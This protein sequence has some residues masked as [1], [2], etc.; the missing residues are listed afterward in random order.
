MNIIFNAKTGEFELDEISVEKY[1]GECFKLTF[2]NGFSF[3]LHPDCMIGITSMGVESISDLQ[4]LVLFSGMVKPYIVSCCELEQYNG[5]S[6]EERETLIQALQSSCNRFENYIT[7]DD[8]AD[9]DITLSYLERLVNSL[10]YGTL[11][12][13]AT[14]K[15]KSGRF[16]RGSKTKALFWSKQ[17]ER[18]LVSIEKIEGECLKFER[19]SGDPKLIVVSGYSLVPFYI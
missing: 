14:K 15:N 11:Y 9:S 12:G 13:E 16:I 3:N 1:S 18:S 2:D 8:L 4:S 19:L 5:L 10:G 7:E 6:I 17:V